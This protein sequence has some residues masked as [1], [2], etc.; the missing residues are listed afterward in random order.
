MVGQRWQPLLQLPLHKRERQD[1]VLI[2]R[3][4]FLPAVRRNNQQSALLYLGFTAPT[5]ATI[6]KNKKKGKGAG[7]TGVYLSEHIQVIM[8]ITELLA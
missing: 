4:I 1:S 7:L 5:D 3:N 6:F 8:L 2:L